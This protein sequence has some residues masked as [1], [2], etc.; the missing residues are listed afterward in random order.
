MTVEVS[1]NPF[2][3]TTVIG[4]KLPEAQE[5]TLNVFDPAG[6]LVKTLQGSFGAGYNEFKIEGKDL[7]GTGAYFF[8]LQTASGAKSGQVVRW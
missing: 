3:E 2:R 1:P 8:R 4:F 7:P 6:R 5:A